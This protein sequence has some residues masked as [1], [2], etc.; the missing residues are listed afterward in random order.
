MLL[1]FHPNPQT[2][3]SEVVITLNPQHFQPRSLKAR[4]ACAKSIAPSIDFA[5]PEDQ[6]R[7]PGAQN[8]KMPKP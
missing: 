1:T 5:T 8:P 3:N 7:R 2:H 6:A 4:A